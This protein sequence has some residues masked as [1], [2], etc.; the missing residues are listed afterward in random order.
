MFI[1]RVAGDPDLV[2]P[3]GGLRGINDAT[4]SIAEEPRIQARLHCTSEG[5]E[6][7]MG[8]DRGLT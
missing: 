5:Y 6:I 1:A 4:L 2:V 3:N 8:V 7:A